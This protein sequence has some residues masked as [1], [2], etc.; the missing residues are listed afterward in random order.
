MMFNLMHLTV[1][2]FLSPC[3]TL[4]CLPYFHD[5][6]MPQLFSYCVNNIFIYTAFF[7]F[8]K[9]SETVVSELDVKQLSSAIKSLLSNNQAAQRTIMPSAYLIQTG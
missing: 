6:S 3:M 9:K 7:R 1:L 2:F 8:A 4:I 5:D